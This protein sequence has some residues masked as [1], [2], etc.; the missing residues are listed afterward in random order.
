MRVSLAIEDG[1]D[2]RGYYCW[3]LT[4][5]FEW[6]MGYKPRFGVYSIDNRETQ[7]RKLK[8]GALVYARIIKVSAMA[9]WLLIRVTTERRK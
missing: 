1:Y 5:N 7:E 4:D 6:N 9:N 8:K 2:V 3:T